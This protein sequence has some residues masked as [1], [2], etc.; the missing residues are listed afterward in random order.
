MAILVETTDGAERVFTAERCVYQR[1][2]AFVIDSNDEFLSPIDFARI[3]PQCVP[4]CRQLIGAQIITEQG[5]LLGYVSEVLLRCDSKTTSYHVAVA[6]WRRLFKLSFHL[7]G[8]APHYYSPFGSRL[9]VTDQTQG[10]AG[11]TRD[12]VG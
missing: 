11:R 6:D 8:D 9:L 7:P 3:E 12:R 5:R 2:S 1:N 4:V 10:E